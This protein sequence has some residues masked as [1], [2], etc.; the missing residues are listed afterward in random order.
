MTNLLAV[1][2]PAPVSAP[3]LGSWAHFIWVLVILGLILFV[4]WWAWHRIGPKVQEPLHTIIFV[5]LILLT[6]LA[7]IF[8]ILLPLMSVF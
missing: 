6:A 5:F 4:V 2:A 7:V 8:W 3:N 1:G